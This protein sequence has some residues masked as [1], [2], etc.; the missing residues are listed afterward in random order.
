MV[1]IGSGGT[2]SGNEAT[3]ADP[4]VT[5]ATTVPALLEALTAS[6]PGPRLTWVAADGDRVD[7]SGRVLGN[8]V[9]KTAN[10]LREEFDIGWGDVV[11]DQLPGH[12]K[13]VVIDLAGLACGAELEPEYAPEN[14]NLLVTDHP[15]AQ[16]CPV[17]AV[18]LAILARSFD[19]ELAGAV[20]YAA[21]VAGYDDV[22]VPDRV[23]PLPP[24]AG[25]IRPG[26]RVLL[27]SDDADLL[28][29][30]LAVWQADGSVVLAQPGA[31][32]AVLAR[33]GA[34]PWEAATRPADE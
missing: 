7:L 6:G 29:R 21:D 11:I 24:S 30:C 33:E 31:D 3:S 5:R 16:D 13:A 34:G 32:P 18:A 26:A 9:A 20:D 19:A 2:G 17:L 8:W 12:W 22:F 25:R 15:R 28:D 27:T 4:R 14:A 1:Q 10:L 23:H